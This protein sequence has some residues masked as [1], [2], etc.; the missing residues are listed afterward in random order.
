MVS[1]WI[2]VFEKGTPMQ[3]THVI[4]VDPG[5]VHSGVV[6]LVFV[7]DDEEIVVEHEAVVGPNAY[8][9]GQ[10]IRRNNLGRGVLPQPFIWIEGY[11][12]R[13]H[14]GT[15]HRMHS[16]VQDFKRETNGTVLLNTG[17]KKVVKQPLMEVLGCWK[18]STTTHHQDLRS[19]AR[20]A[21]LGM[22]KH[23]G[24][25]K[26]LAEVV[27]AHLEGRAWRVHHG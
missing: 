9:A 8:A 22:L 4:G 13:S 26:L 27:K 12:P 10:W 20:I 15:D 18:F 3:T 24:L 16:A 1:G 14:Y 5:L 21:L 19:A 11:K 6:R 17:V 25:N 23:E 2:Y 7:P